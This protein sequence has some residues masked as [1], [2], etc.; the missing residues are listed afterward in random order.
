MV[1]DDQLWL[2]TEYSIAGSQFFFALL[3]KAQK[4][5]TRYNHSSALQQFTACSTISLS[6]QP[7][8][9]SHC[10]RPFHLLF[11]PPFFFPYLKP[12]SRLMRTRA[13]FRV[14]LPRSPVD[15]VIILLVICRCL[16]PHHSLPCVDKRFSN[17]FQNL[18]LTRRN[19]WKVSQ[20]LCMSCITSLIQILIYFIPVHC[21]KMDWTKTLSTKCVVLFVRSCP[22]CI[23]YQHSR[24][25]RNCS[26][27]NTWWL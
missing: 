9:Q 17:G 14:W 2:D 26:W 1:N 4:C 18:C 19:V 23:M 7:N 11:F 15:E 6:V 8:H 22:H 20:T 25:T 24:E 12:Q 13:T 3:S 5:H 27:T 16:V 21:T 10:L